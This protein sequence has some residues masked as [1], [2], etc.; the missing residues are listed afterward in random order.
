[1]NSAR[2]AIKNLSVSVADKKAVRSVSLSVMP[3]ELHVIMG[4]N[5]SGKSSLAHALIGHPDYT[6]E[7]GDILLEGVSLLNQQPDVR[8]RAGLF[9]SFQYPIAIPGVMVR[10][11]LQEI[12]L[13]AAGE[14]WCYDE[15]CKQ[16]EL[17]CD[18]LSLDKSLLA[19]SLHDGFSGGERKKLELL[20]MLLLKP[21]IIVLDEIDS[22]LDVDA[23][24]AVVR[25][26]SMARQTE[27]S[28]AVIIITH[29]QRILQY[30]TVDWVHVMHNGAL[31]QSGTADLARYIDTTGY[32]EL[33]V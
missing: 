21:R 5:G 6:V 30:L 1:M 16:L 33:C 17:Y 24:Q 23:L 13:I 4:P 28:P 9:V 25:G 12:A 32:Q 18:V 11:F 27:P 10:S 31:I 26:I 8:A 29:Y 2:L 3:G 20:Q 7:S 19:R 15:F 22:G 14:S